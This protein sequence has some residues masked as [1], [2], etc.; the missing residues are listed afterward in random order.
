MWGGSETC[1]V[2]VGWE[3]WLWR[4]WG[5][6]GTGVGVQKVQCLSYPPR[7]GTAHPGIMLGT[8]RVKANALIGNRQWLVRKPGLGAGSCEDR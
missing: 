3:G 1:G 4:G 6:S 7:Q 5:G 8:G 2:A